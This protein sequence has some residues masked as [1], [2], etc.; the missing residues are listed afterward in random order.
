MAAGA[1]PHNIAITLLL[2]LVIQ[3]AETASH[4][5]I[6]GLSFSGL[7]QFMITASEIEDG[8]SKPSDITSLLHTGVQAVAERNSARRLSD[9][10]NPTRDTR[11][12]QCTLFAQV[13]C[14]SKWDQKVQ[15]AAELLQPLKAALRSLVEAA[16]RHFDGKPPL[17]HREVQEAVEEVQFLR[18]ALKLVQDGINQHGAK[19]MQEV[20]RARDVLLPIR[21]ALLWVIAYGYRYQDKQGQSSSASV[22]SAAASSSQSLDEIP[23]PAEPAEPA[24]ASKKAAEDRA[25]QET[26]ADP[27]AAAEKAEAERAAVEAAAD[28]GVAAAQKAAAKRSAAERAAADKAAAEKAEADSRQRAIK[29]AADATEKAAEE[30]VEAILKTTALRRQSAF[31]TEDALNA[32]YNIAAEKLD[33]SAAAKQ[34]AAG[35]AERM[36][37]ARREESARL[38]EEIATAEEGQAEIPGP[39]RSAGETAAGDEEA[40]RSAAAR[41]AGLDL[42]KSSRSGHSDPCMDNPQPPPSCE[43]KSSRSLDLRKSSGH[44]DPCKDNPQPP[45]WC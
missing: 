7:A 45:P 37:A 38:E 18:D 31:S 21:E 32:S 10:K 27:A 6:K 15:E 5:S 11:C 42:G 39:A 17:N 29:A 26:A 8:Q 16:T 3:A 30:R 33:K 24:A 20:Q 1:K 28:F 41:D 2:I 22:G 25:E 40:A 34:A 35:A 43:G 9:C 14:Q 12:E 13:K 36:A 4:A 23:Q 44:S 19:G